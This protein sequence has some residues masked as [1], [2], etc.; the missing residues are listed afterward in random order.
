M[1]DSSSGDFVARNFN[2]TLYEKCSRDVCVCVCRS[3][4]GGGSLPA[5]GPS[6]VTAGPDMATVGLDP[7][8]AGPNL[9][10]RSLE[11]DATAWTRQRWARLGWL[12][13]FFKI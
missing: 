6:P 8:T 4:A 7:V 5:A 11:L 1:Y 9:V 10:A 3:G 13:F 2:E 12:G